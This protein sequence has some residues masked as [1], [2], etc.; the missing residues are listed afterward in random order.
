[1]EKPREKVAKRKN[2]FQPPKVKDGWAKGTPYLESH[3]KAGNELSSGGFIFG[4]PM[5]RTICV[6]FIKV[7]VCIRGPGSK[8]QIVGHMSG[9]MKFGFK[10][11]YAHCFLWLTWK[12]CRAAKKYFC[13]LKPEFLLKLLQRKMLTIYFC[14]AETSI[15]MFK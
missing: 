3:N 5:S 8:A 2:H 12:K 7:C 14:N 11:K 15:K 13:K 1:M 9:V 4:Q 6:P 10:P